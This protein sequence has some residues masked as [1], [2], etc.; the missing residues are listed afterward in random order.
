MFI[1]RPEIS[2][3]LL[4][5]NRSEGLKRAVESIYAQTFKKFEL[6]IL[7]NGNPLEYPDVVEEFLRTKANLRY[8]KFDE[9]EEYLGKRLNQGLEVSNGKYIIFFTDDDILLKDA[10]KQL[11]KE[12]SKDLDFVYGKVKSVDSKTGKQ[13]RNSYATTDWRKGEVK[14]I[15]PIHITSVILSRD[16][17]DKIGG[18]HEGMKR[19]FEL[20]LWNRIF[21]E[22]KCKRID[23][24]ISEI[25]VNNLSSVTGRNRAE[26]VDLC[27]EYPLEGYWS[28]RKSVSFLGDERKFIEQI[29]S[30]HQSWVAT[31][32]SFDTDVNVSWSLTQDPD[33]FN[34]TCLYYIDHPTLVHLPMLDLC[35]GVITQFP[36]ETEKPHHLL[37]PTISQATL[38]EVDKFVYINQK[39]LKIL[40]P[41]ITEDNLDFIHI[42]LDYVADRYSAV[43]LYYFKDVEVRAQLTSIPNLILTEIQEDSYSY[44]KKQSIDVI[45]HINGDSD[46]YVDAYKAFLTSS[47]VRAPLVTSPNIAYSSLNHGEDLFIADRV[48]SFVMCIDKAK[49]LATRE[50]MIKNIRK[51]TYLYFLD[52]VV[53]DKFTLFL[54]ENYKEIGEERHCSSCVE[55]LDHNSSV[56][57]HKGEYITQSFR[58]K[59]DLFHGV[60]FYGSVLSNHEGNLRFVLKA[61][62]E[63]LFERVIPKH[64][65]KNGVNTVSFGEILNSKN[66]EHSFTLYGDTPIFKIDYNNSVMSVGNY[67]SNGSPKKACLKF[68][69]LG[70]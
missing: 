33:Q 18:F 27:A 59:T 52:Q 7:D 51:K 15:N 30:R 31:H 50:K 3:I 21:K 54:N 47:A 66:K 41:K 6:I 70:I 36:Y 64:K 49:D 16:L 19:S 10:L 14:R 34:G 20:N 43:Y 17:L 13:V 67:F 38:Q 42:L 44:F 45:L 69:V 63:T 60:Q 8:L 35:D 29:N 25:S 12:I 57:I 62:E 26:T 23:K 37:R 53:L 9:N 40:C 56:I 11:H 28:K 2:I 24:V 39:N 61:G 65:L 68:K 58:P 32:D 48:Q 55:Q 4:T 5:H 46:S 1:E 22:S